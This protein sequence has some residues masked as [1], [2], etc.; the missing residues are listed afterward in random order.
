MPSIVFVCT[1]NRFR[2]PIAET[3]FAS[4]LV[5]RKDEHHLTISSAGTWTV[6]GLP[7]TPEAQKAAL[8]HGLNLSLHKSRAITKNILYQA[9]LVLVMEQNH[10]EA[11]TQEFSSSGKKIYLLSEAADG[12]IYNI[13]DPYGTDERPDVVAKEIIEIINRGYQQIIKLTLTLQNENQIGNT[14]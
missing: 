4:E 1:A 14:R 8:N 12:N 3:Y 2:S 9:D 10:K 13:P 5:K 7:A 11:I 6:D